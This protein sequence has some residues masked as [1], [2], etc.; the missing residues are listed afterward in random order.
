TPFST[1]IAGQRV[2]IAWH[3]W[4]EPFPI[5]VR[6][7]DTASG[8]PAGSWEIDSGDPHT[9]LKAGTPWL[10]AAPDGSRLDILTEVWDVEYPSANQTRT[11]FFSF[12]L[13]EMRETRR[14]IQE[15]DTPVDERFIIWNAQRAPDGR[16]LYSVNGGYYNDPLRVDFFDLDSG[17]VSER[18]ELGFAAGIEISQQTAVSPDGRLLYVFDATSG[19]LATVDLVARRLVGTATVDLSIVQGSSGSLLGRAWQAVAGLF[20]EE[21]AAKIGFSGAMQL[22][23]DGSHLYAIGID[24]RTS[25]PSGVLVINT[26]TWQVVEH[27]LAGE[28]PVKL[29][30]SGDGRYLYALTVNWGNEGESGLR[31]V[32]TT[33]GD[34][35][36][37]R[38]ESQRAAIAYNT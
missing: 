23:P 8:Q 18:I 26:S 4:D 34:E 17:A 24:Q 20:V 29:I 10:S 12:A 27:W 28:H 21:A 9:K 5:P 38:S 22:S 11:A 7:Y 6:A 1:A 2:Y 15:W 33:T 31:I 13:P 16:A 35:A 32:D 19:E 14:V 36:I 3:G 25:S 30:A 37:W